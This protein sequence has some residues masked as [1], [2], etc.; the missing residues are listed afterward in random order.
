MAIWG[1]VICSI[2]YVHAL[3]ILCYVSLI[4]SCVTYFPCHRIANFKLCI[5]FLQMIGLVLKCNIPKISNIR[6]ARLSSKT[7]P[8]LTLYTKNICPLCDEAKLE[9][10][11]YKSLFEFEQVFID[12]KENKHWFDLYKYDIPVF[13]INGKFLMK[14]KVDHELLNFA[15]KSEETE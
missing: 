13:H 7:L 11:P 1:E 5:L 9:L 8:V 14:H 12:R 4:N 3:K 6:F 15:L 2:F 10:E